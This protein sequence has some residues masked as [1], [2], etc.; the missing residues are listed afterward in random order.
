MSFQKAEIGRVE[1]TLKSVVFN[2]GETISSLLNKANI[3][4]SNG[5]G[6][7]SISGNA[8]ELNELAEGDETYFIVKNYKNGSY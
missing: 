5:E 2:D 7:R 6:V 1:E 8:V 4:L 3:T